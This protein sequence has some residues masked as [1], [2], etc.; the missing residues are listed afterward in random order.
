MNI[1][2]TNSTGTIFLLQ[3]IGNFRE[4]ASNTSTPYAQECIQWMKTNFKRY[5]NVLRVAYN[6]L[7]EAYTGPPRDCSF[8]FDPTD[9]QDFFL[10]DEIVYERMKIVNCNPKTKKL[11]GHSIK[12]DLLLLPIGVS[13]SLSLSMVIDYVYK[14]RE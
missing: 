12:R 5:H 8:V 11:A 10:D 14:L 4:A 2:F 9:L 13:R 3:I 7:I 6:K 1:I